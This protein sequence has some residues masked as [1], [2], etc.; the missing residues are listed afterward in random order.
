MS[1]SSGWIWSPF[2]TE[3]R[4]FFLWLFAITTGYY[5]VLLR[6]W[7]EREKNYGGPLFDTHLGC[8]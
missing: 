2:S 8:L 6:E 1:S 5:L 3:S 7:R 4:G